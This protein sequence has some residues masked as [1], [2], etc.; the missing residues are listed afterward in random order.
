MHFWNI[1]K[2]SLPFN[3]LLSNITSCYADMHSIFPS[4][5]NPD[6]FQVIDH[7]HPGEEYFLAYVEAS[8]AHIIVF[9]TKT[10]KRIYG[11]QL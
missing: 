5:K 7:D 9:C 11:V 3:H 2:W 6:I 8:C 10:C 4:K 1:F